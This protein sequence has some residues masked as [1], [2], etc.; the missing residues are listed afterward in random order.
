MGAQMLRIESQAT[1]IN[2]AI[3]GQ[4]YA[5][6][7]FEFALY[8]RRGGAIVVPP[9]SVTLLDAAGNETGTAKGVALPLEVSVPAGVDPSGPVI[10]TTRAALEEQWKPPPTT[11]FKAGDALV[12]TIT[13]EANDVPAMAMRDLAFTAPPGVRVYVEPP[14]SEDRQNRGDLLGRR[15]DRVTY[16]FERGGSFVIPGAAQPW[17]DLGSKRLRTLRAAAVTAVVAAAPAAK[18]R[19]WNEP[20]IWLLSGLA[21]GAAL[22]FIALV[23][24]AWPRL[25]AASIARQA[26][27]LASEPK[28][29]R[30]LE[31]A[32]RGDGAAAIYRA[33]SIWRQRVP[34]QP[35]LTSLAV[36]LE[37]VLFGD[38]DHAEWS[39]EKSR[40]FADKLRAARHILRKRETGRADHA[41]RGLPPLNPGG[42][43]E[44]N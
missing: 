15:V 8:P 5:G 42:A 32:C 3:D 43:Y 37:L 14:Q 23:R 25:R 33:F 11:A 38:P 21:V 29:F 31:A 28:A 12:R 18:K 9:A 19:Y 17:W 7:R 41:R 44:G 26:R 4:A 36:E 39:L 20:V 22:A 34:T 27:W 10:A 40:I 6:Q 1:T 35:V 30:D 2:D 24:W 13:R 16:V